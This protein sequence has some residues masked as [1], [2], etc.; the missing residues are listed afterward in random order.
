MKAR[1]KPEARIKTESERVS[2]SLLQGESAGTLIFTNVICH[3]AHTI[4]SVN[5]A[6]NNVPQVWQVT[7]KSQP[8]AGRWVI[9]YPAP[10]LLLLSSYRKSKKPGAT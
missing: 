9:S 10:G 5:T 3:C 8:C 4:Q 2:L 6:L 1:E 7:C